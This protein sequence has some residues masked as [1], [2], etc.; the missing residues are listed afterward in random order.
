MSTDAEDKLEVDI[1]VGAACASDCLPAHW[2]AA[3]CGRKPMVLREEPRSPSNYLQQREADYRQ[4]GKREREVSI[5][6][7]ARV[8][9]R[10]FI[11]SFK[12]CATRINSGRKTTTLWHGGGQPGPDDVRTG[13]SPAG[14]PVTLSFAS[15]ASS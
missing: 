13:P 12:P 9:G 15:R 4:Y 7:S 6:R 8:G 10:R 3:E 1:I 2:L 11:V 5:D 14:R